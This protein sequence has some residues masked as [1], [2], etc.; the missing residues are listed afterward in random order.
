MWREEFVPLLLKYLDVRPGQTIVDVGCGTG[1]FTRLVA[2]GLRGEGYAIGVDRNRRLVKVAS[3]I[4]KAQEV[5]GCVSFRY[6]KAEALPFEDSFTDR[7][8]CQAVLWMM[9]DPTPVLREM[10]RVCKRGGM[11]GA[12]EGGWDH[13][14]HYVPDDPRLTKLEKKWM[15]ARTEG[16]RK[17]YGYDR[18]TGYKLAAI[19]DELGLNRVRV[20]P[21]AYGWFVAD[22]RIPLEYKLEDFRDEVR[23]FE[24]KPKSREEDKRV[25]LAGGMTENEVEEL[26]RL[27]Y[28]RSKRIIRR[29]ELIAKDFSM[30]AGV[31]FITTG[32]KE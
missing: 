25:L 9:H 29:P 7:V 11:V 20:D 6:G 12:V 19:F 23:M 16:T 8:V 15:V 21:Y 3:K 27:S 32:I 2:R 18:G 5:D 28:E 24:K 30:N 22:D 17:I 13:I 1:F 26:R 10:I 4:A 31:F 14:I